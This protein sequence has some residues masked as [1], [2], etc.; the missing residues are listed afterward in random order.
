MDIGFD[1]DIGLK[2]IVD[3]LRNDPEF[4][5][6]AMK[7]RKMTMTKFLRS[8]KT[9]KDAHKYGFCSLDLLNENISWDTLRSKFPMQEITSFGVDFKTAVHMGLVPQFFGGDKGLEVL[10]TMDASNDDIKGVI[11]NLTDLRDT[12][13]SP[14]T[15][16]KAGFTFDEI[17]ELG[18]I[19]REMNPKNNST[20]TIKQ[21]VLAFKPDEKQWIAGGFAGD[22][23]GWEQKQLDQFVS[24]HLTTNAV[25]EVSNEEQAVLD[26]K[27]ETVASDYILKI[28][29]SRLDLVRF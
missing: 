1:N 27:K 18:N 23:E 15:V 12:A 17:C 24:P 6:K 9:L 21:I 7:Y 28:D 8:N 11:H 29:Q 3:H 26:R 5:K 13:W 14:Q 16:A 10:R 19:A 20:W 22:T 4:N 25:K 2:A